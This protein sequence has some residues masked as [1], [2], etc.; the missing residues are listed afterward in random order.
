MTP[1]AHN[2]QLFGSLEPLGFEKAFNFQVVP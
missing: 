1:K 2:G